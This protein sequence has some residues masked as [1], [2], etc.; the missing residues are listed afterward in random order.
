MKAIRIQKFGGPEVLQLEQVD[1]PRPR[2]SPGEVA[3]VSSLGAHTVWRYPETILERFE[4]RR[5]P[6]LNP[7]QPRRKNGEFAGRTL[8][9]LHDRAQ[10]EQLDQIAT[11]IETGKIVL[12][13]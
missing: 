5:H 11:L 6:G 1:P 3:F 12:S 10:R 7:G 2:P 13:V 8:R 9:R 4:A